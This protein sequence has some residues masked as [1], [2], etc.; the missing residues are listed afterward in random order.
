[1][2]G[3]LV[4]AKDGV[5]GG[6]RVSLTTFPAKQMELL[7]RLHGDSL[8]SAAIPALRL[9]TAHIWPPSGFWPERER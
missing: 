3:G 9:L 6:F 4:K 7:R 2:T 5:Y 8:E 1:M